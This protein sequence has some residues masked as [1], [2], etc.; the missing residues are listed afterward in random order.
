MW[1]ELE[2][3]QQVRQMS[4]TIIRATFAVCVSVAMVGWLW[5]LGQGVSWV[6][7]I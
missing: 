3:R 4:G 5:L 6:L 7:G 2:R 1:S